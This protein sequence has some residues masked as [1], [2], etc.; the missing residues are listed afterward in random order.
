MIRVPLLVCGPSR[1]R[2]GG[3]TCRS[4][5]RSVRC[6]P[7]VAV[8]ILSGC[9]AGGSGRGRG[10][11]NWLV[12]P[13]QLIE[14]NC[15]VMLA[16]SEKAADPK[17]DMFNLAGLVENEFFDIANFF[18]GFVINVDANE[19]G[20]APLTLLMHRWAAVGFVSCGRCRGLRISD[21]CHQRSA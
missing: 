8:D 6:R 2:S 20:R 7:R 1:S 12:H 3:S 17:D 5:C 15:D 18:V 10:R 4:S 19:L 21:A 11:S 13:L 9:S 14:S 16:H